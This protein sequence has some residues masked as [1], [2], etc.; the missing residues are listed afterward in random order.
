MHH[1]AN[2]ETLNYSSKSKCRIDGQRDE[3]RRQQ[4][5]EQG[6]LASQQKG[7]A[8][9]QLGYSV[10]YRVSQKKTFLFPMKMFHLSKKNL[11]L[12]TA[13]IDKQLSRT[14]YGTWEGFLGHPIMFQITKAMMDSLYFYTFSSFHILLFSVFILS[15]F[16]MIR[17]LLCFLTRK[18]KCELSA[19]YSRI[20]S[21][22]HHII[23]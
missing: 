17:A 13:Q 16:M 22:S 23:N 20:P 15:L 11:K 2:K 14:F 12:N 1:A 21:N 3:P 8:I 6:D 19:D 4:L 18:R 9:R 7:Q 5:V 10:P